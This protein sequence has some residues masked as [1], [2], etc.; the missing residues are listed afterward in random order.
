GGD[1][2]A[3]GDLADSWTLQL[4]SVNF[5]SANICPGGQSTPAP[6]SQTLTLNYSVGSET[7][8]GTPNVLTQGAPNL[9]FKLSGITCTD[10]IIAGN[11]C[12]ATVTFAPLAPGLRMGAVQVMDSSNPA[13]V[14]ATT[15]ISGVGQGP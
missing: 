11:S 10:T 1:A 9:D 4:G 5:G 2:G 7:A 13:N 12:S 14:L 6:C 8:F 15:F 3:A